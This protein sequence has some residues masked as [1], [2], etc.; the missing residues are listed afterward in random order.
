[1]SKT[2]AVQVPSGLFVGPE[3]V[4]VPVADLLRRPLLR[5]GDVV[6]VHA[7]GGAHGAARRAGELVLG[8]EVA[9]CGP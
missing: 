2:C 1:M 7:A 3:V 6:D 8:D 9:S 4:D 5:A